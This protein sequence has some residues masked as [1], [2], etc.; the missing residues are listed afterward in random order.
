M[1]DLAQGRI[2]LQ[3]AKIGYQMEIS[4]ISFFP[5]DML[6]KFRKKELEIREKR[7]SKMIPPAP[8]KVSPIPEAASGTTLKSSHPR[9]APWRIKDVCPKRRRQ[10]AH[11]AYS[12]LSTTMELSKEQ[13]QEGFVEQA[14]AVP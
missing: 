3:R 12:I 13:V 1:D 5:E 9:P 14:A 6:A 7:Q 10:L 8:T 2:G 11:E 4:S